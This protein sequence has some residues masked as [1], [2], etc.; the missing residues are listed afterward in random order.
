VPRIRE[1]IT[2]FRSNSHTPVGMLVVMANESIELFLSLLAFI[3]LSSSAAVLIARFSGATVGRQ[4]LAGLA[5]LGLAIPAL[6]TSVSII[7][8]LYFSE[9]IGYRPCLLCDSGL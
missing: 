3:A 5:Q 4:L 1:V 2:T 6:V 7:G 9:T 8:S